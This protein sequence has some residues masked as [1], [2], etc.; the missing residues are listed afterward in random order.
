MT[1][2]EDRAKWQALCDAATPG[3]WELVNEYG[4]RV[5]ADGAAWSAPYRL[6]PGSVGD[7]Q[8]IADN[9]FIAAAREA[10]PKLLADLDEAEALATAALSTADGHRE[11]GERM[12][13]ERDASR[14]LVGELVGALDVALDDGPT[15]TVSDADI[16]RAREVLARARKVM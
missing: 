1:P 13:A 15:S 10:M 5:V 11:Y 4:S 8:Q 12:E 7:P 6:T 2:K 3:P 16:M 9:A 14:E